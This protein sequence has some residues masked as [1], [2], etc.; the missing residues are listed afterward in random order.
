MTVPKWATTWA[1]QHWKLEPASLAHHLTRGRFHRVPHI[2]LIS[3]ELARA[4]AEPIRLIVEVP[5]RHGKSTLISHWFPVWYLSLFPDRRVLFGSYEGEFAAGWGRRVRNTIEEFSAQLGIQL[6]GDSTAADRWD[7]VTGG[8]MNTAGVG[9]AFTGRGGNLLIGD[10]LIKNQEEADSRVIQERNWEWFDSTFMTRL[11]PMASV[12]LVMSRWTL[13]DLSGRLQ[14]EQGRVW[15]VIRLPAIAEEGDPLGRAPGAALWPER[16]PVEELLKVKATARTRTWAALYQQ[17]PLPEEGQ[18]FRRSMFRYY[19]DAGDHFIAKTSAGER[20]IPKDQGYTF[21]TADLAI[22]EKETADYCAFGAYF[23][24][25]RNELLKL[26]LIRDRI[27]GPDQ[28]RVIQD[29]LERWRGARG[30]VENTQYQASLVQR[31]VRMGLPIVG[32]KADRDKTSRAQTLASR[33][34]AEAFFLPESAPWLGVAEAEL[35]EFGPGCPHDD[36][37]DE[38][39]QAAIVINESPGAPRVRRATIPLPQPRIR[40]LSFASGPRRRPLF[41]APK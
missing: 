40:G 3:A 21:T 26:D 13:D 31:L 1:D 29:L 24:S 38:M 32:F 5:V 27:P 16:Y 2:D 10:D 8:G 7:L 23:V 19:R 41:S 28:E 15:K 14:R 37:V 36:I 9:G 20:L 25:A 6:S 30:W 11:E 18:L 35:L 4:A 12:V 22:S 34:E 39:A 33:M 17:R